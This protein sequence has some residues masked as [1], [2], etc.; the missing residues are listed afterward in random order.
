MFTL[1]G[2][3]EMRTSK[4]LLNDHLAILYGVF[5]GDAL[6]SRYEF[7]DEKEATNQVGK[8][9]I[10][11]ELPI[12]G[13]GPFGVLAG[14]LTDDSEMTISLFNSITEQNTYNQNNVALHYIKWFNTNPPDIGKTITKSLYT[15][16][17][18]ENAKDMI[19]NSRDLN[20]A[21][22][23]NGV[24]MRC[25][26]IAIYCINRTEKELREIV[27]Q[28]CELT[29]PNQVVQEGVV[30]YCLA[31]KYALE[32]ND[33]EVIYNKLL[34]HVKM[35]R[36]RIVINDSWKRPQP[37]YLL[38]ENNKDIAVN[39]DDK[40]YQG[41]IGIALQNCL[42]ELFNGCNFTSSLA[43]IV[44]RGGDTDTNAGIA[45]GLLGAYY[46]MDGI[47]KRWL[48][49]VMNVDIERYKKYPFLSPREITKN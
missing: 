47:P 42:Y 41:Y 34:D 6:G 13:G 40:R 38:D 48:D 46:T 29:H 8:D 21:S 35:E 37:T 43:S 4:I 31:I 1:I 30:I 10:S 26:P 11:D 12:L 14:Q 25:A 27:K 3:R 39:T 36:I 19:E 15:R 18:S 24:L 16:K 5:V 7:M 32:K 2:G 45:G 49:A 28:E 22:L 33:R 17:R 44:K 23:S 9:I 20:M